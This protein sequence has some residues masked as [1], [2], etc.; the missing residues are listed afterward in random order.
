M[1]SKF[2]IPNMLCPRSCKAKSSWGQ[3]DANDIFKKFSLLLKI[4]ITKRSNEIGL[5]VQW[6]A[7]DVLQFL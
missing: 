7:I 5:F 6:G 1:N 3:E 4:E 2:I